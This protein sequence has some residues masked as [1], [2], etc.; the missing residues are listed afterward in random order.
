MKAICSEDSF[1]LGAVMLA[2]RIYNPGLPF[3]FFSEAVKGY[4]FGITETPRVA[5]PEELFAKE[6]DDW[7]HGGA[8]RYINRVIIQ[9]VS[10]MS[11]GDEDVEVMA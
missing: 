8:E 9:A 10:K 11:V 7:K 1:S 3:E 5:Y 4:G 6:F 2:Q